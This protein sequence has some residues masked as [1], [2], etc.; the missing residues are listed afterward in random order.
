MH[1]EWIMEMHQLYALNCF[2]DH[3]ESQESLKLDVQLNKWMDRHTYYKLAI[4]CFI[5]NSKHLKDLSIA[6]AI[7]E[8]FFN[9]ELLT[10]LGVSFGENE[11][12][13]RKLSVHIDRLKIGDNLS[14]AQNHLQKF[15][16]DLAHN[17]TLEEV[18][19]TV[20]RNT[21]R[22]RPLHQEDLRWFQFV[23]DVKK[24][25]A[26]SEKAKALWYWS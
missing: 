15:K 21:L 8:E 10:F 7:K 5:K 2:F 13:L 25:A 6:Y 22:L 26:K 19:L 11:S 9:P 17:T 4:H 16:D 3:M 24:G 12:S 18:T 20:E 14:V 23:C 1:G